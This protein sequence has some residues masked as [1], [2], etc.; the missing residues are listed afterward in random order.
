MTTS[1]FLFLV[2]YAPYPATLYTHPPLTQYTDAW[3]LPYSC[4]ITLCN[5]MDGCRLDILVIRRKDGSV[6]VDC[7]L[8][9]L[10][11]IPRRIV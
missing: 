10:F 11:L 4:I 5:Y 2:I 6:I 7:I 8:L 9:S 1:P 3:S